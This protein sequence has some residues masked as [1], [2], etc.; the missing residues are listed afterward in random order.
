M[1]FPL[2]INVRTLLSRQNRVNE[3]GAL[4][5]SEEDGGCV[6]GLLTRSALLLPS[7]LAWLIRKGEDVAGEFS[8][9]ANTGD[10]SGVGLCCFTCQD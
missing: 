2:F 4:H 8:S 10:A 1:D 5:K 6:I 3:N 7:L 9:F